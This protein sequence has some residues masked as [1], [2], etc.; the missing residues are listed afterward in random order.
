M[1]SKSPLSVCCR[2]GS[3]VLQYRSSV[4][5]D[6]AGLLNEKY[7]YLLLLPG[8]CNEKNSTTLIKS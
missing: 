1:S 8:T 6:N 5:Y 4:V 7:C 3:T 2:S